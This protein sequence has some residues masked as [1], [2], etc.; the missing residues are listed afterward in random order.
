MKKAPSTRKAHAEAK[1]DSPAKHPTLTD[2]QGN[3]ILVGDCRVVLGATP[4]FAESKVDLIF[5]DPPFNWN[6]GYDQWDDKMDREDY[7]DFTYDWVDMCCRGLRPG[8]SLFI[9]IPDDTVAEIV[10]FLKGH[11]S[12]KPSCPMRMINWCLWHYR[13][14]QNRTDAFVSSKVNCLYFVKQE[15]ATQ[16]RTWNPL[17]VLEPSDRATTY[18]DTRTLNK[19]DGMPAGMRVPLDVWYGPYWGRIQGNNKE[20]RPHHD[21]QLP[22][23]Y[24]DRVVRCASNAGDLV[25]DPF[26][27]SGTTAVVARALG[28]KFLGSEFS[29]DNATRCIARMEEGLTRPTGQPPQGSALV[30]P[31]RTLKVGE[32][33]TTKPAPSR[34]AKLVEARI[35]PGDV[36]VRNGKR[37]KIGK[38]Q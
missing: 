13:F 30:A 36:I 33:V 18:G 15:S 28:R 3:R 31:R 27:G 22:E 4:E 20:R 9:N 1:A 6:R 2:T 32:V 24:L 16:K 8:G 35:K 11:M 34:K 26:T 5:A 23:V 21:N 10:C 37:V 25:V 17:D 19:K 38:G 14:G 29:L 7:L 12:R